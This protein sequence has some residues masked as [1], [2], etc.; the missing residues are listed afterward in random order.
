MGSRIRVLLADDQD[1]MLRALHRFIE[2][3]PGMEVVGEATDG[4]MAVMMSAELKPDVLVID[5][6]M[7]RMGGIEAVRRI[8]EKGH[9]PLIILLTGYSDLSTPEGR[10][11]AGVHAYVTKDRAFNE[12]PRA[13]RMAMLNRP[14]F[15]VNNLE[16]AFQPIVEERP[17][18]TH[19]FTADG[20]FGGG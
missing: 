15:F 20:P 7:P 13:I 8:S 14:P 1:R 10:P 2:N 19:P 6:C 5:H 4:A 18:V 16:D 11:P 9:G 3:E 12:L 17:R